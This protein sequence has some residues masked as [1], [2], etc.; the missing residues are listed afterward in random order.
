MKLFTI[1]PLK[2]TFFKPCLAKKP[3]H[4][5]WSTHSFAEMPISGNLKSGDSLFLSFALPPPPKKIN[6]L[7][8]PPPH[9]Q[10]PHKQNSIQSLSYHTGM[11]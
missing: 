3:V 9:L 2:L 7:T 4:F 8:V 1:V 6:N 10:H 5:V 11:A